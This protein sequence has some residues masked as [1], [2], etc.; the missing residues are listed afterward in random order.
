MANSN[1]GKKMQSVKFRSYEDCFAYLPQEEQ[2]IVDIL[3]DIVLS[4]LPT[5]KRKLSYNV[6]FYYQHKNVCY[7]WPG[8]V[9]W[10]NT[11]FKGVQMGFTKG[12]L[13]LDE[14]EYLRADNRKYVRTKVY[15]HPKDI[16]EDMLRYFLLQAIE[17]DQ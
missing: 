2:I 7:I 11:T 17:V 3:N 1:K 9:P 14:D 8:S 10:G 13:L 4:T 5:I 16:E 12:H 6:P 15:M